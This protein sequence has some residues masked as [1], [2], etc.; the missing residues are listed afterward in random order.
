MPKIDPLRINVGGFS[1]VSLDVFVG[2]ELLS[3]YPFFAAIRG[4]IPF[5][6]NAPEKIC[7]V[8]FMKPMK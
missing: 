8:Y 4:G 3:Q 2:G 1:E 6:G 7:F 5:F